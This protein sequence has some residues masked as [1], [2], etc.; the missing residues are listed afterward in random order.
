MRRRSVH[1]GM[2]ATILVSATIGAC[3]PSVETS[4]TASGATGSG[5]STATGGSTT[6][7]VSSSAG[8][9][10]GAAF[11]GGKAGIP[12]AP[13]EFCAYVPEDSC[14]DADGGGTCTTSPVGCTKD[15][16]GACGCDGQF[17]CNACLANAA[18]VDVR[19]SF[20]CGI[21]AGSAAI[22]SAENLFTNVPRFAVFKADP[23]RDLCFRLVLEADGGNSPLGIATPPGWTI[24]KAEVTDHASDCKLVNGG[25]PPPPLGTA[26]QATGGV[27][28]IAFSPN[29]PPCDLT[30]HAS[31]S[32]PKGAPWVP[33]NEPLNVDLLEVSGI[34]P[35]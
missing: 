19:A 25:F 3:G 20:A 1:V 17:Y 23:A 14:G 4:T 15:C 21:D 27:G 16:P 6:A 32:F 12:C 7:M 8:E 28:T 33:A 2:A 24:G 29:F 10:G 26:V 30:I 35:P 9:G 13:G 5:G 18:G 34:C 11:C 22:Y 31:L